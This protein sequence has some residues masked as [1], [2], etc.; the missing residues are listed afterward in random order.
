VLT[1]SKFL[2]TS[3]YAP[4]P[5]TRLVVERQLIE[6]AVARGWDREVGT[7]QRRSASSNFSAILATPLT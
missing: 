6:D 7:T 2:T 5:R 4:R 3:D 1:C